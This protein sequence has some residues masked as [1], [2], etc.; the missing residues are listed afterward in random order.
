MDTAVCYKPFGSIIEEAVWICKADGGIVQEADEVSLCAPDLGLQARIVE[1]SYVN[2][3]LGMRVGHK[4]GALQGLEHIPGHVQ[5]LGFIK[6]DR[7]AVGGLRRGAAAK[8][9]NAERRHPLTFTLIQDGSVGV[10]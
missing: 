5:V 4:V 6:G 3:V 9:L 7:R 2:V 10:K 8:K 1:G